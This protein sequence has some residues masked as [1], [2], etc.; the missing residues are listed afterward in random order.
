MTAT[1]GL[2]QTRAGVPEPALV[3]AG[4]E[5]ADLA[6]LSDPLASFLPRRQ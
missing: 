3:T 4:N 6:R 1:V 2:A 5:L